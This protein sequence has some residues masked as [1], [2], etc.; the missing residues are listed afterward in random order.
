MENELLSDEYLR[1]AFSAYDSKHYK[2]C[3]ILLRNVVIKEAKSAALIADCAYEYWK[4]E[5]DEYSVEASKTSLEKEEILHF[6]K[7]SFSLLL[8]KS[9][10]DKIKPYDYIRLTHIYLVEGSLDGALKIMKLASARGYLL[11]SLVIIQSW[12]ILKRVGNQKDA[13]SCLQY[14]S[15]SIS[16]EPKSTNSVLIGNGDESKALPCIEGSPFP[17]PY[18]LMH[19]T[20]YIQCR[21]ASASSKAQREKDANLMK[22]MITEAYVIQNQNKNANDSFSEK[23]TWFNDSALWMEMARYLETTPFILLA[24]DS[25][26]ESFIRN[27]KSNKPIK[28]IVHSMERYNRKEKVPYLLAK[29]YEYN[30]WS[31]YIRKI[32]SETEVKY[33]TRALAASASAKVSLAWN[34]LFRSQSKDATKV[35]VQVRRWIVQSQWPSRKA[36]LLEIKAAFYASID[37]AT[38]NAAKLVV[39]WQVTV[40]RK[41]RQA[42][43]EIIDFKNETATKIETCWRRKSCMLL[44]ERLFRRVR[45]AN[46]LFIVTCQNKFDIERLL[47]FRRWLH[48]F[49]ERRKHKSAAVIVLVIPVNTYRNQVRSGVRRILPIIGARKRRAMRDM[50]VIWRQRYQDRCRNH[51]RITIRFFVRGSFTRRERERQRLLLLEMEQKLQQKTQEMVLQRDF[52]SLLREM[53]ATW[54]SELQKVYDHRRWLRAVG[55]LTTLLPMLHARKKAR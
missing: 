39:R 48:L 1:Q 23:M 12:T 34:E 37:L 29:A 22:S 13:E 55:S 10:H 24:E 32:L 4:I 6:V 30:P 20:N 54:R 5:N 50:M 42:V 18:A 36:R 27:P 26:W 21:M 53:W 44:R 52:T 41:W 11:N 38:E 33:A 16:M 19:C 3:L 15:S 28:M 25:Y 46:A 2:L 35:Q 14:L 7:E 17:L 51:A 47:I 40:L 9:P 45:R 43:V 8:S 31:L 49:E